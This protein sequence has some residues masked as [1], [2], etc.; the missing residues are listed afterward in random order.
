M[1]TQEPLK[2]HCFAPWGPDFACFQLENTAPFKL[3]IPKEE[4]KFR[5]KEYS[6]LLLSEEGNS[7]C[8]YRCLRGDR[9]VV[10]LYVDPA[11]FSG[12]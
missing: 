12:G 3:A 10:V 8:L 11:G 1:D 5:A 9:P 2:E 4:A 7:A 6:G